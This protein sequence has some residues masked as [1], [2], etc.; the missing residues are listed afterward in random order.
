MCAVRLVIVN[1]THFLIA[2]ALLKCDYSNSC[3]CTFHTI[4]HERNFITF[5][6][7]AELIELWPHIFQCAIY[8]NAIESIS[9]SP[10]IPQYLHRHMRHDPIEE[11]HIYYGANYTVCWP[12]QLFNVSKFVLPLFYGFCAWCWCVKITDAQQHKRIEH[13]NNKMYTCY[14]EYTFWMPLS[15]Y[16][17]RISN[18]VLKVI[19][20][21]KTHHQ[22]DISN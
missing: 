4:G 10:N 17:E 12:I 2:F 3:R 18:W 1:K 21:W 11:C 19:M 7:D 9:Y 15:V 5:F 14:Y 16:E 8:Y 6:Y 13:N 22:F 20:P